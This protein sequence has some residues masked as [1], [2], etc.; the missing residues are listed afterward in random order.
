VRRAF[1][2]LLTVSLVGCAGPLGQGSTNR[3]VTA[4]A[5]GTA[6]SSPKA[7]PATGATLVV[8]ESNSLDQ[9]VTVQ[10]FAESGLNVGQRSFPAHTRILGAAA[11][12]IF[13]VGPDGSLKAIHRNGTTQVLDANGQS[14]PAVTISRDGSHWAWGSS[15]QANGETR[16]MVS[17]AGEGSAPR[18][19][20][21]QPL[22]KG[23]L[24]PFAWTAQGIYVNP[25][26]MDAVGYF[27]FQ[28]PVVLG[29]MKLA[30]PGTGQA[31]PV[32]GLRDCAFSDA[33]N[34]GLI[35]CYPVG[36]KPRVRLLHAQPTELTLATPRFNFVGDAYFSTDGSLLTVGGA[37]GVG[38][39]EQLSGGIPAKPE[40]YG[41]DL[42]RVSDESI[43]R[44][45]PPGTRV[46]MGEESWLPDGK[47]VLWRPAGT[48]G[49][50]PGLYVL[51]PTGTGQGPL[52][53][54]AGQPVGYL[55]S[56]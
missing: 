16:V 44:F 24:Q 26:P 42:I 48:A 46:A 3:Q 47:L 30:N 29:L 4:S 22:T 1:L 31:T 25:L 9:P 33:N 50:D 12:S 11:S 39:P 55:T 28:G 5:S 19:L 6:N 51:D 40:V 27:P 20:L 7:D 10:F 34:A 38:M 32:S 35:A 56:G 43:W 18:V 37:T 52:I 23:P 21:T 41:V 8:L 13:V 14:V 45:G 17:T 15:V 49:G 53:H 54:T 36:P 2:L